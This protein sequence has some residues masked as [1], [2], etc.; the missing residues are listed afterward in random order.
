MQLNTNA[1]QSITMNPRE[2]YHEQLFFWQAIEDA[3]RQLKIAN[4]I[5]REESEIKAMQKAKYGLVRQMMGWK[6]FSI[7]KW[8]EEGEKARR[9]LN[10]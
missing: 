9:K 3:K 2:R 7:M 8:L 5:R 1:Q 6:Y 10:N 4:A